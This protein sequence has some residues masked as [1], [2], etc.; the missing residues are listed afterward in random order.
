MHRRVARAAIRWLAPCFLFAS[1]VAGAA[2]PAKILRNALPRA[3]T[4]FDPAL[5]GEIYS[6]AVIA[7]IMEPL[8]TFDYL[9]RPVK[10]IPLTAAALPEVTDSGRTCTFRIKPGIV[11]ASDPVLLGEWIYVDIDTKVR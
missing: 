4:G 10:I 8:L 6:S 11:F 5:A 2:D 9:A 3:E 1:C 7:A